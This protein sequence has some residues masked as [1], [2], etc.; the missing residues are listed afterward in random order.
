MA[1]EINDPHFEEMVGITVIN[2]VISVGILGKV[3]FEQIFDSSEEI[4]QE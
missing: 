1:G 2:G 3:K 4:T